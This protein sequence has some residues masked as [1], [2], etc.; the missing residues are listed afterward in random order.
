MEEILGDGHWQC[1]GGAVSQ[2]N[3]LRSGYKP[4]HSSERTQENR[5]AADSDKQTRDLDV[6]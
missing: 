5:L 2:V 1:F 6:V 4:V 3:Q